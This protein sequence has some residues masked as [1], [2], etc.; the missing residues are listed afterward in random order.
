MCVV[1][2]ATKLGVMDAFHTRSKVT[3]DENL[4][5]MSIFSSVL[6]LFLTI[7]FRTAI[8]YISHTLNLHWKKKRKGNM[9]VYVDP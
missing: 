9:Y 1:I 3:K 4:L 8:T 5:C 2:S 6:V 7:I